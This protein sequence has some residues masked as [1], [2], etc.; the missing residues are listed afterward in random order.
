MTAT[1]SATLVHHRFNP[2]EPAVLA[3]PYPYYAWLRLNDPMHWGVSGDSTVDGCWYVTRY[4]DVIALLKEPRLGREIDRVLPDR[5][6][7]SGSSA[8]E[9]IHEWMVLRDPPDHTHLRAL[10]HRAFTPQ[11]IESWA[12]RMRAIARS[13][14]ARVRGLPTFDLLEQVA[15]PF[16]VLV[17]AE[18][19]GV[20]AQD[21]PLFMPWTKA[22]AAVIEF[23]QSQEVRAQGEAAMG[24]L[25]DYLQQIIAAR[26]RSPE[27][28]L[29][30]ALLFSAGE[31]PPSDTVLIGACTQLLFGGND[32]VAHLIGN[33]ILALL[34]HPDQLA[35]LRRQMAVQAVAVDELMRYDSSVQMT[36][37]Y[38]LEEMEWQGRSLH[39]GDLVALVFGAANHDEAQFKAPGQLDL[40]RS[41]NRHLSLGQGIH[42]CLGA[43]LARLEGR[44]MLDVI[45][46]EFP[47][48][49]LVQ[50]TPTW[51]RTAAVRGLSSLPLATG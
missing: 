36:F 38:V 9:I 10:V 5:F 12:P 1:N 21:A 18:M 33:G 24:A 43:A 32:P 14:A 8:A 20:P 26:R 13:L 30:S 40:T 34:H 46:N 4:A 44:I 3:D 28:D 42:Y 27:D 45:L 31:A 35:W 2:L 41:P 22:L 37:R 49:H 6:S 16:P 29:I 19:L 11:V 39:T 17:V 50:P 23:E 48:L 15:T 7:P 25:A 47:A 51:Q